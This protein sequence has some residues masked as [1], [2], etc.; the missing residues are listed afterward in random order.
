MGYIVALNAD[1][2]NVYRTTDGVMDGGEN[3]SK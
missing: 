1:I 2:V 3:A